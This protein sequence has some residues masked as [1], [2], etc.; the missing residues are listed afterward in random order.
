M[1]RV[2]RSLDCSKSWSWRDSTELAEVT[3]NLKA[4]VFVGG[5]V[6]LSPAAAPLRFIG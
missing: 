6:V 4:E 5:C 3:E 1:A 2:G